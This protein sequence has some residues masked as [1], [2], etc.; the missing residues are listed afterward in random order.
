MKILVVED[1]RNLN[2]SLQKYLT[3]ELFQVVSA[4][5]FTEASRHS[6]RDFDLV[7]LDWNLSDGF[8]LDLLRAWKKST[9][10]LPIIFLTAK[11]DLADKVLSLESGAND[12]LTK[13]FEPRELL[14][15]IRVQLRGANVELDKIQVGALL[16]DFTLRKVS[17]H[18]RELTLSKTEFE[19]L[20]FLA[21]HPEKVFSREELLKEVW[22]YNSSPTTRTVDTHILQLRQ[23]LNSEMFETIH[24]VGYRMKRPQ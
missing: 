19:L 24:G 16:I 3:V 15:R 11:A 14:A 2:E 6:P 20:C 8:G 22:G 1:D 7:I 4:F 17:W 10:S 12:Y 18:D 23:K 5:S 21:R 9:P 13:P